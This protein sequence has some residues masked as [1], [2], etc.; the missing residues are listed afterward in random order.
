M[1]T[2]SQASLVLTVFTVGQVLP[3][4]KVVTVLM[5]RTEPMVKTDESELEVTT[6]DKEVKVSEV[7]S[8]KS[9]V[10]SPK[11]V[12]EDDLASQVPPVNEVRTV[13]KVKTASQAPPVFQV[14]QALQASQ[15]STGHPV[16]LVKTVLE[17]LMVDKVTTVSTDDQVSQALEVHQVHKAHKVHPVKPV[18]AVPLVSQVKTVKTVDQVQPVL[19]VPPVHEV[20]KVTTLWLI[21]MNSRCWSLICSGPP[22]SRL[23]LQNAELLLGKKKFVKPALLN[24]HF[25]L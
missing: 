6:V 7:Q 20:P 22:S 17:V 13:L 2:V 24:S 14:P 12:N 16:S 1:L 23:K 5:L 8:V 15:V 19:Q 10:L 25:L 4:V 11:P 21:L 9:E 3:A 18:S